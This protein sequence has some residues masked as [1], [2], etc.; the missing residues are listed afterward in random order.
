MLLFEA[1]GRSPFLMPY[2]V[3]CIL[4]AN[5]E[6]QRLEAL[7]WVAYV[8]TNHLRYVS[9]F[10][11]RVLGYNPEQCLMVDEWCSHMQQ[12]AVATSPFPCASKSDVSPTA[13]PHKSATTTEYSFHNMS[14]SSRPL[15]CSCFPCSSCVNLWGCVSLTST[16]PLGRTD[17]MID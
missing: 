14:V 9:S 6:W 7:W 1:T 11:H 12:G 15:G 5:D 3:L 17:G 13:E 8:S 4:G 16:P 2:K 10:Y